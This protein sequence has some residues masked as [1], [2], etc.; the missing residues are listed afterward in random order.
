LSV[1]SNCFL[2]RSPSELAPLIPLVAALAGALAR[3]DI[4]LA[5]FIFINLR[6]LTT[7]HG[8]GSNSSSTHAGTGKN[9]VK[10]F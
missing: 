6:H 4:V 7:D 8:A 1:A 9:V 3:A 5:V 10:F 2:N